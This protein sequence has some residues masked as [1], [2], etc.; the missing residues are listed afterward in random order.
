[1]ERKG[2]RVGAIVL[3]N[4]VY[5]RLLQQSLKVKQVQVD[6]QSTPPSSYRSFVAYGG[7]DEPYAPAFF[8]SLPL[9]AQ[10]VASSGALETSSS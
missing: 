4:N 10:V 5:A 1:M 7:Y 8:P 9:R 2:E 3:L 6:D